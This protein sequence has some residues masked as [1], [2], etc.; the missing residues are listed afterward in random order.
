MLFKKHITATASLVF[1]LLLVIVFSAMRAVGVLGPSSLR[2]LLPL[3]FCI[4][5][6]LP[7]VLLTNAGRRDIG[8]KKPEKSFQYLQAIVFGF[9][10]SFLC[11]LLGYV[12]F[13]HGVNNWYVNISN[14]YKVIMDTSGMS[15]WMLMLIF[16]VPAIIFS[17]IGEE[18]F[19]RGVL[20]KTFEQKLSVFSS[21]VIECILFAII[22]LVHHGIIKTAAGLEF[23]PVSGVLWMVQMF[24]VA[25]M[26]AWL[27]K[28]SG[29]IFVA[30][31]AHM[32]F[33]LTMN[34]AIFLFLW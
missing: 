1:I 14:S 10:A 32:V 16:T 20:Q 4:M 7:W 34:T 15:F 12:L 33:N 21:T 9:A 17:P 23:L 19:Y 6:V 3:G 30:I 18:I 28:R 26:F 5:A 24:F 22:H 31:L 2:W 11:F 25:L 27:R 8:L 13:G 29:S